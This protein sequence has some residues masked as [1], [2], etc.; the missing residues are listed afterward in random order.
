LLFNPDRARDGITFEADI[1]SNS[2]M[3]VLIKIQASEA[4]VVKVEDGKLFIIALILCRGRSWVPGH[5]SLKIR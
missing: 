3:D 5:W 1:L 4:V 2:T